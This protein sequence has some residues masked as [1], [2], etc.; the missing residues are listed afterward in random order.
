MDSGNNENTETT[1]VQKEKQLK[2]VSEKRRSSIRTPHLDLLDSKKESR[3]I[4]WDETVLKDQEKVDEKDG[5]NS[6]RKRNS[7]DFNTKYCKYVS[8]IIKNLQLQ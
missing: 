1:D 5:S 4:K 6:S 3:K 2:E 8:I 7:A